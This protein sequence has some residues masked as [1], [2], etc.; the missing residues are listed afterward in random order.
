[1]RGRK[2]G[3][4]SGKEMPQDE[5]ERQVAMSSRY[6]SHAHENTH[7]CM[8]T[9]TRGPDHPEAHGVQDEIGII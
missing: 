3:D 7:E 9:R 5:K 1:M 8:D 4:N 2:E 6:R